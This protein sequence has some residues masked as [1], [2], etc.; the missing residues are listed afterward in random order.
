[1]LASLIIAFREIL[2]AAMVVGITLGYL[3]K[4]GQR[5]HKKTVWLAVAVGVIFSLLGAVA[6]NFLV[7]GFTGRTE[8]IFEGLTMLIGAGL[9][10][11]MIF[12]MRRQKN[13]D[14]TIEAGISA[15]M[16]KSHGLGL[17]LLIFISVFREG[18][19]TVIFLGTASFA[20]G[21]NNLAGA[22]GGILLALVAAY[23][24]Y[25]GLMKVDIRKFFNISG[26]LLVLFAAGLVAHGLHELQEAGLVPA[27]IE[28]V[29][30]INPAVGLDGS[31]PAW[32]DKG[33]FGSIL[34]GL[35][36]YNGDPSLIEVIGYALYLS[37]VAALFRKKPIN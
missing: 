28:R 21:G 35:F 1:M 8:M 18:I 3:D 32:H 33:W 6:F 12:W 25:G 27:L 10:T 13:L 20:A 15:Q 34:K 36:G 16:A 24:V 7:G 4:T 11:L 26:I 2:E 30:D 5:Q 23:S 31:Y 29:W 37:V 17:F 19:E 22:A 14:Q 9:L